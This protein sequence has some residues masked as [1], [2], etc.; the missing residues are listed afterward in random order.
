M[1]LDIRGLIE[2]YEAIERKGGEEAE[3]LKALLEEL[4]GQGG[5]EKWRGAWYPLTLTPDSEWVSYVRDMLDDCGYIPAD[6][7]SWIA[8]DWEATAAN[9][10]EDYSPVDY[11]GVT[12]WYSNG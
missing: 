5:D 10:Q 2:R 4:E 3:A 7:P 9:V 12:Y 1:S 8:I 6:F 11:E